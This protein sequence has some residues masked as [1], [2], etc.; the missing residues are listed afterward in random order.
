MIQCFNITTTDQDVQTPEGHVPVP[1]W[2]QDNGYSIYDA[3]SVDYYPTLYKEG[4]EEFILGFTT[5]G[6]LP[7]EIISG[8]HPPH[9]PK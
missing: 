9:R 3:D 4:S 8:T 1:T 2:A 5:D 6:E 7:S